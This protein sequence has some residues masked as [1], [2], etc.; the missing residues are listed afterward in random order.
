VTAPGALVALTPA[1]SSTVLQLAGGGVVLRPRAL[2]RVCADEFSISTS[3]HD[4][5]PLAIGLGC[6]L[7]LGVC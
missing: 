3:N 4:I 5:W 2:C 6:L 1:A 7:L